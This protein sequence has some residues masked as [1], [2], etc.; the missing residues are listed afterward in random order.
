[1]KSHRPAILLLPLCVAVLPVHAQLDPAAALGKQRAASSRHSWDMKDSVHRALGQLRSATL[2]NPLETTVG[3]SKIYTRVYFSCEKAGKTFS[4]ELTNGASASDPTGFKPGN[5]PRLYCSRPIQPFDEKLVQEEL[6]AHWETGKAGES[7]TWG[8]R[9]FPLRECVSIRVV[10][11]ITLPD[12]WAQKNAKVEF[13]LMPY[14]REIDSVFA[15]CGEQSAYAPETPAPPPVAAA[16]TAPLAA[17]K[18]A[19]PP[20]AA[21]KPVAPAAAPKLAATPPPAPAPPPAAPTAPTEQAAG[22]WQRAR[23]SFTGKTNVRGGPTLQS[24][25]IKELHPGS[26]VM[27]QKADNDWWKARPSSGPAFDGYI[28]EDRLVFK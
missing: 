21:A 20:A 23:T 16:T 28:R 19:P 2:R 27:V 15:A 6:L 12:G 1:M 25:I 8:L 3:S 4:M 22:T 7:L 13:D 9:P 5:E 18:F 17:L 24:P 26:V 10:Q 14:S 11:E